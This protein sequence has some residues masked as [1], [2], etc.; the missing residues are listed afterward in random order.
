MP[1]VDWPSTE[2][3]T[4]P[5]LLVSSTPQS[6]SLVSTCRQVAAGASNMGNGSWYLNRVIVKDHNRGRGLGSK[7]LQRV[8]KEVRQQGGTEI[9]V[10]PG[11]YGSDPARLRVF[12]GRHGFEP[13]GDPETFTFHMV[14]RL[15]SPD[16]QNVVPT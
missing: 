5:E 6:V 11:G 15:H 2:A 14:L 16:P 8:I 9:I 7:A 1:K 4:D 10:E 3:T 12:Y 13:V